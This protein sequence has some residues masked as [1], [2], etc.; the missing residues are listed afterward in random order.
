MELSGTLI[1]NIN[2]LSLSEKA[3]T[4]AKELDSQIDM[5]VVY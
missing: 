1:R 5:P 3:M 2:Q 4:I